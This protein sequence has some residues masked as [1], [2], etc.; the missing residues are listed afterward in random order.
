MYVHDTI[1][2]ALNDIC[3]FEKLLSTFINMHMFVFK[4]KKYLLFNM[5]NIYLL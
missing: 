3:E 4:Y 5:F 1:K 2:V